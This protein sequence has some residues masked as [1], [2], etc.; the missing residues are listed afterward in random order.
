MEQTPALT[1]AIQETRRKHKER[2]ANN[3]NVN[4]KLEAG[5][6][7]RMALL[8]G[9]TPPRSE[10]EFWQQFPSRRK[11]Q[12]VSFLWHFAGVIKS[13]ERAVL[14]VYL[15]PQQSHMDQMLPKLARS[16]RIAVNSEAF[17]DYLQ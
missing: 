6:C 10:S 16:L 4:Y 8:P 5:A 7:R 1:P 3:A 12:A 11:L 2:G 9:L 15:K 13:L 17:E 14:C